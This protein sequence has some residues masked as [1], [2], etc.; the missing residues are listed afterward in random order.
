MGVMA[1]GKRDDR[2]AGRVLHHLALA[3]CRAV[4][5][6]RASGQP[7]EIGP[8]FVITPCYPADDS[9]EAAKQVRK[10]APRP[11]PSTSIPCSAAATRSYW[12]FVR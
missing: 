2:A 10:A 12:M 5:A 6:F 1:P 11:I 9:A 7:G 8:C 3:H 4:Q